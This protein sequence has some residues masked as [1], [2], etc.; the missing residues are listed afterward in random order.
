MQR[1]GS[2]DSGDAGRCSARGRQPIQVTGKREAR[3]VFYAAGVPLRAGGCQADFIRV[4]NGVF[5]QDDCRE[6]YFSG[7]NTWQVRPGGL[8]ARSAAVTQR[9]YLLPCKATA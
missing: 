7:Y 4:Q 5:V 6:W 9:S 2:A 3:T 8:A 1:G